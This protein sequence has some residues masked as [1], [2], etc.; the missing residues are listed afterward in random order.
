MV[1]LGTQVKISTKL[2]GATGTLAL[3][4]L[5]VAGTGI[6]YLR[7]LGEE[8]THAADSSAVVLDLVNAAR[9]RAWEM[10]AALRG[11]F[12]FSEMKNWT[13][14]DAS[15]ARWKAAFARAG[16]Q[17]RQIRPL[18]ETDSGRRNLGKYESALEEFGR[19]SAEYQQLA[20][21]GKIDGLAR[22]VPRVQGFAALAEDSL[23]SLKVEERESL[24]RTQARAASLRSQSLLIAALLSL[25]LLGVSGLAVV[26]VVRIDRELVSAVRDLSEG[27]EQVAYAAGQV[28]SSSQS[29]AQ[30]STE[31]AASLEETSASTEE[32][33]SMARQNCE[34][35]RNAALL[36]SQSQ[37]RFAKVTWSLDETVAAMGEIK[38]QSDKI[39]RINK[40]IEEIAFQTN[41]LALNAAVEAARAGEAGMGFAVVADEVRNLSERSSRAAKDTAALIEET[42]AKSDVG[43]T[44]VDL[45]AE[46]I[47]AI[48]GEASKVKVLVDQLNVSS[49]EQERGVDQIAKAVTQMEHVTQ[50]GAA[51]AQQGA[52][53]AAELNAQSESV[54][55]VVERLSA[56]VG[57]AAI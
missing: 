39:S 3:V 20:R 1:G 42:V 13:E 35:S 43:K 16:E 2:H 56:M 30:G 17:I 45:V 54:K 6:G 55:G 12:L 32:I 22:L 31:Q 4:G 57:T 19:I 48:V 49:E 8:L 24:K 5:L 46:E 36:V 34:N 38:I 15:V 29:L 26:V 33:H 18:L 40:A 23:N 27:A 53:A 25:L 11:V 51:G 28:A 10:V 37:D 52:S 41:I 44:K 9:A 21:E 7:S 47:R 50:A 14:A